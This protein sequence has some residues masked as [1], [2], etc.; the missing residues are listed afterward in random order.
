AA[1]PASTASAAPPPATAGTVSVSVSPGWARVSVDGRRLKGST[2]FDAVE[3]APG[4]HTLRIE[5]PPTGR[6]YLRTV[7]VLPGQHQHV[8]VL[9]R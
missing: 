1:P 9:A 8:R 7:E 3:L 5:H 6:V 2:P 4:S